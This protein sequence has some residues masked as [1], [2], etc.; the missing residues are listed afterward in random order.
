MKK[1]R[2][3]NDMHGNIRNTTEEKKPIENDC[4]Y[5]KAPKRNPKS[6]FPTFDFICDNLKNKGILRNDAN[7]NNGEHKKLKK[8]QKLK[9]G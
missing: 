6:K 5:C 3:K 2:Y 9:S 1:N 8:H 7:S 4:R